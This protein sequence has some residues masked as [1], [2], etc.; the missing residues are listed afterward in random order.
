MKFEKKR[1]QLNE[2]VA[3]SKDTLADVADMATV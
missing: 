3:L 2:T 1:A